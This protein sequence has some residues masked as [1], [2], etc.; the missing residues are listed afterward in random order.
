MA[1]AIRAT[2]RDAGAGS[3]ERLGQID[4]NPS[5]PKYQH[6]TDFLHMEQGIANS[7][8]RITLT[9]N[10]IKPKLNTEHQ[11]LLNGIEF[12]NYNTHITNMGRETQDPMTIA[13][14]NKTASPTTT[15]QPKTATI[16]IYF[17]NTIIWRNPA[18]NP[19]HLQ[20]NQ[21]VLLR[22]EI[23]QPKIYIP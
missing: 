11:T 14:S 17:N 16:N 3:N 12:N 1:S 21:I 10:R 6:T 20:R 7:F 8:H 13:V 9:A 15:S 2:R 19:W 23:I 22:G 4:E 18:N 5:R